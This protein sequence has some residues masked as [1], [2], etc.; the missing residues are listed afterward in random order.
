MKMYRLAIL[1]SGS[2]TT[3]EAIIKAS[4]AGVLAGVIPVVAISNVNDAAGLTK[5]RALGVDTH[6]VERKGKT[7]VQFGRELVSVLQKYN[8][9]IVSQNGWLPLTPAPVI[10]AYKGNIINQ[11]PGPLDPGKN[12]FGGKG[13][14]GKRVTAA[15]LA[16]AWMTGE[17]NWTESTVHHVT[18]DFDKG[19]VIRVEMLPFI[20]EFSGLSMSE[21]KKHTDVFINSVNKLTALLLPLEH[22]NVISALR[23]FG[24]KDS[25]P[26]FRRKKTLVGVQHR[27]ILA[28]A[29]EFA[30]HVFSNG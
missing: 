2:G 30:M 24:E 7:S 6:V 23:L 1:L 20:S 5:A 17:G 16:Y 22:T 29:K 25:F 4:Q 21:M 19:D 9:M 14:Y 3:A 8:V 27:A 18:D 26:V 11:H 10:E 12:D 13:M 15:R 28:Q